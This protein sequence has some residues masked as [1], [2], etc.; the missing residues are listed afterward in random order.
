MTGYFYACQIMFSDSASRDSVIML[1]SDQLALM[2]LIDT[3]QVDSMKL[4]NDESIIV[5]CSFSSDADRQTVR[6]AIAAKLLEPEI[7]PALVRE[8]HIKGNYT[9]GSADPMSTEV[10]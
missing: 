6:T 5:R 9:I 10:F 1:I 3:P 4:A 8:N 7:S 2:T